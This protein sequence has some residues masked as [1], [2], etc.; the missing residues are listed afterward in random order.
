MAIN[1]GRL[2][3]VNICL[4]ILTFA[5]VI[6]LVT[7]S[8]LSDLEPGK[9]EAATVEM[10]GKPR[11]PF[12]FIASEEAYNAIGEPFLHLEQSPAKSKLPD[13]RN[14]LVSYG[15]TCRPDQAKEKAILLIGIRGQYPPTSV[16]VG[17]KVYLKYDSKSHFRWSFSENNTPTSLWA[18]TE[19]QGTQAIVLLKM[20]D[21]QGNIVQDTGDISYFVLPELPLPPVNDAIQDWKIGSEK[22][23]ATLFARQKA[24]WYGQDLFLQNY[25]DAEYEHTKGRERI[26]FGEN[27]NRHVCFV[28]EG[29]LL[30]FSDDKWQSV[31]AGPDSIG[32]SLLSPKKITEQSIV[33]DLWDPD[34]KRKVA[35]ELHK[36]P[37]PPSLATQF[38]IRLVGARSRRDWIAEIAG[39]RLLLR[40]DDWLLY[41]NGT[42]ERLTTQA[43]I[44]DYLRGELRGELIILEGT[45]RVD[46]EVCL[47]GVRI[48]ESKTKISPVSISLY[49][50]NTQD[51][52]ALAQEQENLPNQKGFK[53]NNGPHAHNGLKN[54]P[55][56]DEYEEDED[57]D[58]EDED[59]DEDDDDY[60]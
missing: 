25:G 19:S 47:V 3:K 45:S 2:R 41:R 9:E 58:I 27:E 37:E 10:A 1:P 8:F 56:D 21:A 18:E 24:K 4:G 33:F 39:A 55:D 54:R 38:D 46:N 29:D 43:Q 57:E 40:T 50:P 20:K 52:N 12:S 15:I 14:V 60:I 35:I 13:L 42:C 49:K 16:Y 51:K 53:Q 48:N 7:R 31:E 6:V 23:D 17:E 26:E 11:L 28:K 32:K 59:E 22:V 5:L 34:G 36:T 30:A 44:D